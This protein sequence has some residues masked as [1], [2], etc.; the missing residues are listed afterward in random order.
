MEAAARGKGLAFT[1]VPVPH[2]EIPEQAV[3]RLR[4]VLDRESGHVL[5]YCRSGKR[6]ARTWALAE[7]SRPD[8]LSADEILFAVKGAGQDA[9]DLRSRIEASVNARGQATR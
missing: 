4:T 1:Y 7:A 3:A 2:G 6:A 8:G 9:G 5:L